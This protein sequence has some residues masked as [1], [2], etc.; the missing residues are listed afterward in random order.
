MKIHFLVIDKS[1][2]SHGKSLLKESGH[3]VYCIKQSWWVDWQAC[4]IYVQTVATD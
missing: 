4:G 2:K 1:W 3:P